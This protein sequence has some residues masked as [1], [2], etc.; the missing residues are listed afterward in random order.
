MQGRSGAGDA[1]NVLRFCISS[2]AFDCN[3][4]ERADLRQDNEQTSQ[5]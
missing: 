4:F 5:E 2:G 3:Q 1:V